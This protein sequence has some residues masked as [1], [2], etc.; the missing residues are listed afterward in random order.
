MSNLFFN[1]PPEL[2]FNIMKFMR[3]PVAD[4]I[5]EA[6]HRSFRS[7]S[8]R[9]SADAYYYRPKIPNIHLYRI[10]NTKRKYWDV[11]LTEE[12][13]MPE[14]IHAYNYAYDHQEN[15]R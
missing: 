13:M 4:I 6:M 10:K 14:D 11:R 15:R 3:H 12:N 8:D 7:A 9:G 1:L 5:V 2:Q